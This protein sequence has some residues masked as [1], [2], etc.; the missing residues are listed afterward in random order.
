M[1]LPPTTGPPAPLWK[2]LPSPEKKSAD[3]HCQNPWHTLY[4]WT[5]EKMKY[6]LLPTDWQIIRAECGENW[7]G[8]PHQIQRQWAEDG[9]TRWAKQDQA[10]T[11]EWA[12]YHQHFY[13][14]YEMF[15]FTPINF[16]EYIQIKKTFWYKDI[17][18]QRHFD[19]KTSA[20]YY[21]EI[22]YF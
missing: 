11:K 19:T 3:A 9:Q 7:S 16:I 2:I 12:Y 5:R 8:L 1:F 20:W 21:I 18:I 4:D 15:I 14:L 6:F 22:D 13:F 17:L 10:P